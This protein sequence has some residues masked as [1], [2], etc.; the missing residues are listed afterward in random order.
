MSD[1]VELESASLSSQ[2][3]LAGVVDLSL[4]DETP[5]HAGEI[6]HATNAALEAV[7]TDLPG[8]VSEADVSRTLNELEASGVVE[9][10][11]DST[12]AT[13]KG[14]PSYDLVPTAEAVRLALAEDDRV[15][16]LV[17]RLD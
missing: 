1:S 13:G 11:R 14:R 12:S 6:R 4:H 9:G 8:T 7:E 10:T 16:P 15:A 3:V 17:D 5:A 2:V